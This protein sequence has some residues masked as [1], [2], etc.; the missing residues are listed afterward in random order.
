[1]PSVGNVERSAGAV[2]F[3]RAGRQICYLLLHY[4]EGHWDFPKGHIE[5]GEKTEQTVHR[6][7]EEETGIRS[8]RLI[9][10]FKE[11]IRYFFWSEKKRILKFVVY[12]LAQ[13]SQKKVAL[14]YEHQGYLWL[15]FPEALSQI[16]FAT[17]RKVLEKAHAFLELK[18][19]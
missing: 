9:P 10:N 4:E 19:P 2:V 14:S 7:I 12:L 18:K 8:V 15:P 17:S 6:E 11:T 1:M 16:T 3:H 13:T 5:K